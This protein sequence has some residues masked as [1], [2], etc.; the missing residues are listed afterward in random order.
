MIDQTY[1]EPASDMAL[2]YAAQAQALLK[3]SLAAPMQAGPAPAPDQPPA[4]RRVLAKAIGEL[5][6]LVK[7]HV[8]QYTKADGTVVQAHD[9]K[10]QAHAA[11]LGALP[12]GH[13]AHF[14]GQRHA[15]EKFSVQRKGDAYHFHTPMN[16]PGAP[17]AGLDK[18]HTKEEAASRLAKMDAPG[19]GIKHVG[20]AAPGKKPYQLKS[21][22]KESAAAGAAQVR[23]AMQQLRAGADPKVKLSGTKKIGAGDPGG[24]PM[25]GEKADGGGAGAGAV[26]PD[27]LDLM[28]D[29][30]SNDENSSD[31]ELQQHWTEQGVPAE[32][33]AAA[34]KHRDDVR[35]KPLGV[36]GDELGKKMAG[37]KGSVPR[38]TGGAPSVDDMVKQVAASD[39]APEH[40]KAAIDALM[41]SKKGASQGAPA[42]PASGSGDSLPHS[43]AQK[44]GWGNLP[45]EENPTY[46][47]HGADSKTLGKLATMPPDHAKAHAHE[48]LANRGLDS[49]GEWVGFD[50]AKAHHAASIPAGFK[51]VHGGDREKDP[52]ATTHRKVLAAAAQGQ[53]DLQGVARDTLASRGHDVHGNWV[54]FA[55]AKEMHSGKKPGGGQPDLFKALRPG[56][57]PMLFVSAERSPILQSVL[58]RAEA[59]GSGDLAHIGLKGK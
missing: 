23:E 59:L 18:P 10:V 2:A 26:D 44:A 39:A 15:A 46:A 54:G 17:V 37:G 30:L 50:K 8:D 33:A 16:A 32:H 24:A 29:G 45:D 4:R 31:E 9:T 5:G 20:N 36:T 7:A 53:L 27:H 49:R 51:P 28:A 41:A 35:L 52:L 55:K 3:A 56:E 21:H 12:D 34:I 14:Q 1:L 57:R 38:E 48:E 13:H 58:E 43:D 25:A 42:K 22:T 19:D 6:D 47:M 40:K 11:T